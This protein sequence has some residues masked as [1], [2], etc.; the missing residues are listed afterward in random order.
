[1]K[2]TLKLFGNFNSSFNENLFGNIDSNLKKKLFGNINS[3]I[4]N[5]ILFGNMDS[6]ILRKKNNG[7][8]LIIKIESPLYYDK[9]SI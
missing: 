4:K 9:L 3:S 2:Y 8:M 5:I 1:M 7:L 6:S